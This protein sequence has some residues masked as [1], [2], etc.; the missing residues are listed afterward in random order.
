MRFLVVADL[1]YSLPQYDWVVSVAAQFDLVVI[2]G[3]HLDISSLV[4]GRA[5]SIVVRKYMDLLRT[6][7]RIVTCSGNH[8]LDMRD[9]SGEKVAKWIGD[10]R[11]ADIPTDG[12]SLVIGDTLFTM[13]PWWDGPLARERVAMQLAADAERRIGQWIW[14][15]HAPA[16]KSPTSWAGTR[17]MGDA[18]L[19][20]WIGQYHPD[21]VFS[22]HVHQSP[23]IRGGSWVDKIGETWV[24][25]VGHQFGAPP[26]HIMI[27]TDLK[28]VYWR[29]VTGMQ[30]VRLD[31]PLSLPPPRVAQPPEWVIL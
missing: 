27:D 29:S 24:F 6:K 8:D 20:D 13:C 10:C 21:I 19:P 9:G 22:G 28:E 26:A 31:E 5:Q 15:H 16:D 4:D 25:N 30:S 18:A 23:F 7:T 11:A 17:H 1:H 2:A 12:D 3:D 14:I